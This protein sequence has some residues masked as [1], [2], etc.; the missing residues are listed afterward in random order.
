MRGGLNIHV[1]TRKVTVG[2]TERVGLCARICLIGGA[3]H[4]D[5]G[6]IRCRPLRVLVG[7]GRIVGGRGLSQLND[8]GQVS[9]NP[10][11]LLG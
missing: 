9:C 5:F 11:F 8:P 3:A 10:L 6:M 2:R 7:Q 1:T 4:S